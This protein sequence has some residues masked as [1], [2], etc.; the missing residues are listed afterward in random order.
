VLENRFIKRKNNNTITQRPLTLNDLSLR[1]VYDKGD[2]RDKDCTCDSQFML[3]VIHEVGK[4]IRDSYSFLPETT[5]VHLYMDNAGGHGKDKVKKEYVQILKEKYNVI[6]LWQCSNSPETNMLDL[7]AWMTIQSIVEYLHK[8]RI[9]TADA[10][11]AT[12]MKAFDELDCEKLKNIDQRWRK[13][14]D[15]ILLGKGSNEFVEA[16]RGLTKS[17][18]NLPSMEFSSDEE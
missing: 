8:G 4:S 16:C 12:V 13:V 7:G 14:M 18:V 3:D 10:L 5:P 15:L 11:S 9:R 2:E 6:V 17:L 1:V